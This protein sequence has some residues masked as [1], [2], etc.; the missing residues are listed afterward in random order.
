MRAVAVIALTAVIVS[1]FV[2]AWF[3]GE[4]LPQINPAWLFVAF[5]AGFVVG[6][7][8]LTAIVK[9]LLKEDQ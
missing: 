2:G 1:A 5:I 7:G 3:V 8:V 6:V 4:L 9:P